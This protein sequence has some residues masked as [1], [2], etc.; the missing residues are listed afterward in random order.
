MSRDQA[1]CKPAEVM[2]Q[3]GTNLHPIGFRAIL[4]E[5]GRGIRETQ[6]CF[7]EISGLSVCKKER[8]LRVFLSAESKVKAI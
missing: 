7:G 1:D 3:L 8:S 2:Q 4:L 6:A 5:S